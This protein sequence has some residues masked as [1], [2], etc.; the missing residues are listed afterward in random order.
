MRSGSPR[1]IGTT[2]QELAGNGGNR[3]LGHTTTAIATWLLFME[4]MTVVVAK[5]PFDNSP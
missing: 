3:V 5:S 4:M 2:K 1:K